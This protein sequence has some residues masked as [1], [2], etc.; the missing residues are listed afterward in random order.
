MSHY[1]MEPTESQQKRILQ[2][3]AAKKQ[4][5]K[6][7]IEILEK[8][9]QKNTATKIQHCATFIGFTNVNGEQ[10]IGTANFCRERVCSVCAW[11]RQMRFIAQT[12]PILEYL[13]K[14][15]DYIFLTLTLKNCSYDELD[16]QI[17]KLLKGY[18]K[19]LHRKEIKAAFGGCIRSLELTYN[20]KKRTYHP[21]IHMLAAV[22]KDY[23]HSGAYITQKRLCQLWAE[24]TEIDYKPVCGIQKVHDDQKQN[25]ALESLKYAF[26]PSIICEDVIKAFL[27]KLKGRRLISFSGAFKRARKEFKLL[28]CERYLLDTEK[29]LK[30]NFEGILYEFDVNGGVYKYYKTI[31]INGG[32]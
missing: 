16:D 6:K 27:Y 8:E 9:H 12:L 20:E 31:T 30:R 1:T 3:L 14:D 24:V 5:N 18:D 19:L 4:T 25:A 17:T 23:W 26:K 29:P 2:K 13:A 7:V 28:D 15:Y 32:E 11:R 21:H 22:K 10:K